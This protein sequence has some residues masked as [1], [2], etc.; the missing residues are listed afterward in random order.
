MKRGLRWGPKRTSTVKGRQIGKEAEEM[1][2]SKASSQRQTFRI[3]DA[4]EQQERRMKMRRSEVAWNVA[5]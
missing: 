4:E 2:L 5:K 3:P 1:R